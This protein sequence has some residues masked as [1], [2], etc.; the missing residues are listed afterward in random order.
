MTPRLK[1]VSKIARIIDHQKEVIEF[2]VLEITHRQTLEKERLTLL[3]KDLYDN[4]DRFEVSLKNRFILNS[5]EVAF[6]FTMASTIRHKIERKKK[7]IVQIEKEL[8]ALQAIFWEA[9]KKKKA[10]E[11]VQ[12]KI[13]AQERKTESVLEQ[14]NIDYLNLSSRPRQ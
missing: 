6:L 13:L 7:E 9:Y 8:T 10:I 1:T 5:E 3:E 12:N 2:Q 11:I 14:K 4:I